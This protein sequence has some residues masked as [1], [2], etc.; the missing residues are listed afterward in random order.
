MNVHTFERRS[1]H[2]HSSIYFIDDRNMMMIFLSL[3]P[4]LSLIVITVS[5]NCLIFY[6]ARLFRFFSLLSSPSCE[7]KKTRIRNTSSVE[8]EEEEEE[9][10]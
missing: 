10:N 2:L 1:P 7:K 3:P 8:Q 4:S 9:K 6:G 5:L